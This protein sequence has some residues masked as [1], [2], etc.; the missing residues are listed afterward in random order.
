MLRSI[1]LAAC[2]AFIVSLAGCQPPAPPSKG[3]PSTTT[4]ARPAAS[5][6]KDDQQPAPQSKDAPMET[7]Q[8]NPASHAA[9]SGTPLIPRKAFF[10]NP[11]KAHARL[12]PDGKQLAYL[13]PVNGVLNI[14]VGPVDDIAS[15]KP[16][17]K[18]T[19][20]G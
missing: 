12:S 19:H 13:A 20:R 6:S 17:T 1:S 8:P 16:V 3:K 5:E 2:A 7:A 10:G 18:D 4:A 9:T 14:W 15:A 11:E